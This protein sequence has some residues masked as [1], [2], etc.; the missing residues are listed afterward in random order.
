MKIEQPNLNPANLFSGF[1]FFIAGL[2]MLVGIYMSTFNTYGFTYSLLNEIFIVFLYVYLA[3]CIAG[4]VYI[5]ILLFKWLY[6]VAFTPKWLKEEIKKK[7]AT[8]RL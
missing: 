4:F 7:N 6:W 3:G 1:L 8:Q 2:F 5:L